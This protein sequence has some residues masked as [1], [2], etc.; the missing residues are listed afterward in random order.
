MTAN[1][2][3]LKWETTSGSSQV[4]TSW[5]EEQKQKDQ[6][7]LGRDLK[8]SL[9]WMVGPENLGTVVYEVQGEDT[10]VFGSLERHLRTSMLLP[11]LGHNAEMQ[12]AQ[13]NNTINSARAVFRFSEL[14]NLFEFRDEQAIRLFLLEH[15]PIVDWLKESH[16]YLT[17]HFGSDNKYVLEL[18]RFP[19]ETDTNLMVYIQTSLS[20]QEALGKLAAF[21]RDWFLKQTHN[22]G[23]ILNFNLEF[24]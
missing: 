21:D 2:G 8:D 14:Q 16:F 18:V 13:Q 12:L 4:I 20:V 9:V 24:V 22:I 1:T 11:N 7:I 17:R 10:L 19:G 15:S 3:T 6:K 23:D 5:Q